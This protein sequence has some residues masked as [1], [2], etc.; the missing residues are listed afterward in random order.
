ML[1][2]APRLQLSTVVLDQNRQETAELAPPLIVADVEQPIQFCLGRLLLA[3]LKALF[4]LLRG[5]FHYVVA[6]IEAGH[7]LN[8][9]N[10]CIN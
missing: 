2:F 8:Q 9:R 3:V 1:M 6:A 5:A 4:Q 10:V 7:H